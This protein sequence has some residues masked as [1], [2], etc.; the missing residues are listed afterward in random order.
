MQFQYLNDFFT[1]VR[2]QN[3]PVL[4][5][6]NYLEQLT[7]KFESKKLELLLSDLREYRKKEKRKLLQKYQDAKKTETFKSLLKRGDSVPYIDFYEALKDMGQENKLPEDL[8]AIEG[9]KYLALFFPKELSSIDQLISHLEK[10]RPA[11][12]EDKE[13]VPTFTNQALPSNLKWEGEHIEFAELVKALIEAKKI[14]GTTDKAIFED[15]CS[16]LK[17][18][19]FNKDRRLKGL[20][21]RIHETT[22][23]LFKLEESLNEWIEQKGTI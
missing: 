10:L 15:L 1:Q 22:P 2:T 8:I 23:L 13:E 11:E 7:D 14:S 16:V 5:Q 4:E 6:W 9:E 17:I 20:K 3:V 19:E 12:K 18:E 21:K